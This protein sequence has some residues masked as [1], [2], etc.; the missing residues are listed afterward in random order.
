MKCQITGKNITVTDSI[1]YAIESKL[2]KMDK[3][4]VINEEVEAKA[5][6]GEV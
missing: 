4:F 1:R 3:Y 6:E 5:K 2:A